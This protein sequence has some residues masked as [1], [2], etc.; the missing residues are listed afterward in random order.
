MTGRLRL[1]T[2]DQIEEIHSA[3]LEILREPG[4]AVENPEALR[5]LREAGCEVE[6]ETVRIDEELVD[7]CLKKAPSVID[8]YTRDG[9]KRMPVGG[10][11][12]YFSPASTALYFIDHETGEIRRA[13][14]QDLVNLV[15]VADA[16]DSIEM[17]STAVVPSDVPQEIA[18]L[19]RLY[20]VLRNSV[21]P[22]ITG[23]FSKQGLIDMIE[24]LSAVVGGPEEL[25][26]R[27]IAF[28]DCCPRSPLT[29]GDLSTQN[30]LD[31][32]ERMVPV[33]IDPAPNIGASSP[34]TLAGTLV[35]MNAELLSGYVISQLKRAGAPVVYGCVPFVFDMRYGTNRIGAVEAMMVACAGAELGKHYGLPTHTVAVSDSK[36]VDAQSLME[37]AMGLTL[38][39]LVRVNNISGPGMLMFDNCQSLEKLVIDAEACRML[40][41]LL[42]GLRVDEEALA[43]DVI[44]RVGHGGHFLSEKH[45]RL[46]HLEEVWMPSDVICRLSLDAW[47]KEGMKTILDRARERVDEIL[48]THQPKPLPKEAEEALEEKLKAI[49]K[50]YGIPHPGV[51]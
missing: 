48:K 14:A 41:R 9:E 11:N 6:G 5:L 33:E 43:V 19:Y 24:M 7:E 21:K 3:T 37:T 31:C 49:L 46:H 23:A 25:R 45:T 34:V 39:T 26:R 29:W 8:I 1:L 36:A 42:R 18:D 20:I 35:Q 51:G 4:I 15:R 13:R 22:I 40:L 50:R 27:P 44:R 17:L 38:M 10:D 30:L 28:F 16:L 12:I 2:E 47:R 32:A